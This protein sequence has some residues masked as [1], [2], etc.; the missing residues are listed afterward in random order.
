MLYRTA[1][2]FIVVFWLTM[3]GLLVHQQLRPDDS[4]LREVPPTH[5]VKLMFMHPALSQ[6]NIYS[7]KL[8]LG[9]LN[10]EPETGKDR[11]ERNLKF[12]GELQVLIPGAKRERIAWSGEL[13]MDKLLNVKQFTLS[14]HS[15]VPAD[16]VS[17]I[18]VIPKENIAHYELQASNGVI[19]RQD[20]TLDEKGARAAL[21]QVGVDAAM[22]PIETKSVASAVQV[23]ARQST[24][25]VPGGT[26]DTYLVTVESNGQTLLE[27]HVD[28][29]G[30]VVKATTLLG[31]TLAADDKTP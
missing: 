14:V 18:K 31:Y 25:E 15:H 17:Y 20:Y 30:R 7:D 29:L 19:E 4:A 13:Q 16:L 28:Q 1:I 22:L 26:M 8:P 23:K 10:I 21:E 3:T 12:N 9:H 2:I 27:C 11:Q 6:L 5:V 24:L